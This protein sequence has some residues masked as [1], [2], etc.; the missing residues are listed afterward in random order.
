MK[1][2]ILKD[3]QPL[4][5]QI[6]T[7]ANKYEAETKME[8][9]GRILKPKEMPG[10]YKH[11]QTI[12]AVGPQVRQVKPGDVIEIDPTA[13]IVYEHP[14]DEKSIRGIVKVRNV[15]HVELPIIKID[16][17][18]RCL[19]QERDARYIIKSYIEK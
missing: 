18:E 4:N 7:T 13:Y 9:Q 12:L 17:E 14:E 6:L 5:S 16:G 11:F 19:L 8:M 2:L 3:I 10:E 15:G 1:E